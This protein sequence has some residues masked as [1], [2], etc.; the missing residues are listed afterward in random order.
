M[1]F[2]ASTTLAVV[3]LATSASA[4]SSTAPVLNRVA[5]TAPTTALNLAPTPDVTKS[6]NTVL[7]AQKTQLDATSVD[8]FEEEKSGLDNL[9][10]GLTDV[11]ITVLRIGT[12][13][14]MI[15]HGFDKVQ[16]VV[17]FSENVVAKFFGFLPGNPQFW[18]LSAAGTQIVGSCF[19]TLG[20]LTR[21]VAIS[22]CATMAV[23]VIFHLLNTGAEGFPLA[24]VPQHS[25]NFELAAMYVAVLTYF[26]ASG[27]GPYSVDNLV[28]GG[29]LKFYESKFKSIFGGDDSEEE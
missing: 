7:E 19:L 15:H 11:I 29:E 4:F 13:A 6:I 18:T 28:L 8:D 27:A 14:L 3:A 17:G 22:M 24:V 26:A 9:F 23:A 10:G 16:N 12:C 1:K 5:T 20:F 25:Y 2:I 21:P